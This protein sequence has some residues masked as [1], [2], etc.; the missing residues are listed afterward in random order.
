MKRVCCQGQFVGVPTPLLRL[1]GH[2]VAR[3]QLK[4]HHGCVDGSQPVKLC[5]VSESLTS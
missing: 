4:V 5:G 1:H 2:D 3:L